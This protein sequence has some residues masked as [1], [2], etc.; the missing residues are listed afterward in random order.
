MVANIKSISTTILYLLG[1]KYNCEMI[2]GRVK[3][4]TKAFTKYGKEQ[5]L[6]FNN[7]LC[8]FNM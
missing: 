6:I 8:H 3:L 7:E 2:H 5:E 1:Y 4:S